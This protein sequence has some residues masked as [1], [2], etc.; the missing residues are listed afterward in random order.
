M[1]LPAG[2]SSGIVA[3][4]AGVVGEPGSVV[5]E[6]VAMGFIVYNG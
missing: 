4:S 2:V 1:I 6:E 5:R 3:E